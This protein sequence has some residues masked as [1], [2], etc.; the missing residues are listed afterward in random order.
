MNRLISSFAVF[1]CILGLSSLTYGAY[2]YR[3]AW[4]IC[5]IWCGPH[6]EG[7]PPDYYHVCP[8]NKHCCLNANCAIMMFASSC[9]DSAIQC[10]YGTDSFGYPTAGCVQ[11][12][13]GPN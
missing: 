11:P 2:S 12:G 8:P 3:K 13:G 9:C 4:N 1:M 10:K 6:D 5:S 7:T